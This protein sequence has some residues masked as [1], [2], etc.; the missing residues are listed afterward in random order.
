L[1]DELNL[2]IKIYQKGDTFTKT[3]ISLKEENN[4]FEI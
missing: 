1:S 4:S 3:L 2:I